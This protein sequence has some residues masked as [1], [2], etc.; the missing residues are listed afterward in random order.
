[1]FKW[2][3]VR[4]DIMT[5]KQCLIRERLSNED[6]R[7]IDDELKDSRRDL[8]ILPALPGDTSARLV[9]WAIKDTLHRMESYRVI[10][11]PSNF[12][13]KDRCRREWERNRFF[14]SIFTFEA[15]ARL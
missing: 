3:S 12:R 9:R 5:N 14:P 10:I 2:S 11:W 8:D 7:Y 1:M 15:V 4:Q 13:S 6:F